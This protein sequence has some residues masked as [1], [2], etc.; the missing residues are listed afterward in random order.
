MHDTYLS[1]FLL[2][3]FFGEAKGFLT[4]K[5]HHKKRTPMLKLV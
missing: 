2:F 3:G 5:Q 4:F 1:T